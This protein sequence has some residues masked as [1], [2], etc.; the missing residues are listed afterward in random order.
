MWP[1]YLLLGMFAVLGLF[2][3][4]ERFQLPGS[5]MWRAQRTLR[6]HVE[7]LSRMSTAELVAEAR[8]SIQAARWER[9]G[10][11][12]TLLEKD[13]WTDAGL[14]RVM[15]ELYAALSDVDRAKGRAGPGSEVFEFYDGGLA[16]I[17]EAIKK[18]RSPPGGTPA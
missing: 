15:D 7:R 4:W 10:P 17:Y 12:R 1:F 18:R 14:L 8:K 9:F 11:A 2:A 13:D 3:V 6:R 5:I 16:S